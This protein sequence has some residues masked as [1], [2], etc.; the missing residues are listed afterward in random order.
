MNFFDNLKIRIKLMIVFLLMF[1]I[2]FIIGGQGLYASNMINKGAKVIY[3]EALISVKNLE[4][5][6]ANMQEIRAL[7]ALIVYERDNAKIE[8]YEKKMNELKDIDDVLMAEYEKIPKSDE[9]RAV[10]S[11]FKE[12]AIQYRATRAKAIEAAKSNDYDEAQKI[13]AEEVVPART[14]MLEQLEKNINI[15]IENAKNKNNLNQ[16]HFSSAK[17]T[18]ILFTILG[19]VLAI[20]LGFVLAK[21]VA[22]PLLLATNH[23]R[24][25][26]KGDFTMNVPD[27]YVRRKDEIGDIAKAIDDLQNGLKYLVNNVKAESDKIEYIVDIVK[28]DIIEL[29]SG[30]E[31]ISATTEELSASMEQTAASSEEMT[32][33]SQQIE[34]AVNIIAKKSQEGAIA[35]GN[36]DKRAKYT[37]DRI[38]ESQKK[39][40]DILSKTK[41]QLENS[42]EESKVVQK[43]KLLSEAIMSITAQTN[44]LALNAAIEA[45]RAGEAGKGFSVVAEEIRKLAEESKSTVIEIQNITEK[46]IESVNNLSDS[47]NNLLKFV[48]ID[49][50]KDY[51]VMLEVADKYSDDAGFVE[52]LV[53]EFSSASEELLASIQE[54]LKTI[55][56]VAQASNEGA[57]GTTNIAQRIGYINEKTNKIVENTKESKESVDILRTEITKFKL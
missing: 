37:K 52:N 26:A 40:S 23:I 47:S 8:K 4:A 15:N 21:N 34:I 5:I 13:Y 50:H 57:E 12:G 35:A 17:N 22:Y 38:I 3:E 32:A 41:T 20:V 7:V 39:A 53:S 48:S 30:I 33:T 24:I 16:L 51:N 10:Y 49:I 56:Q 11:S 28:N 6:K 42:I 9:E 2:I 18:V 25:V 31:D 43:I 19:L 27:E 14:K 45:A 36:I 54:V 29:N 46:V 44:L 1:I 55:E